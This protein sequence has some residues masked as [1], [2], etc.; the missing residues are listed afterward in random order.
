MGESQS[1]K[2]RLELHNHHYFKKAFTKIANDWYIALSFPCNSKQE[3]I[4]LESFI[5]RMKSKTFIEKVIKNPQIL[6]DISSKR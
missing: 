2:Q 1:P 6:T 4:Y 5:K 3:A